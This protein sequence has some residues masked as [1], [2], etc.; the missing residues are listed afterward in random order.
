M[1]IFIGDYLWYFVIKKKFKLG[2][3]SAL[4]FTI[5]GTGTF[6]QV[7]VVNADTEQVS[8]KEGT[9]FHAWCWSFNTIKDNMQ[10][11]KDAGY[12]SVQTS[13]INAVVAGN[14]GNKSLIN[15]Y[16]QYNQRFRLLEITN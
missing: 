2:L 10:A 12:T 11:I 8:M 15:W 13:P 3:G 16:Y 14:G 5:L 7:S 6:V 4:I 1:Y 9:V